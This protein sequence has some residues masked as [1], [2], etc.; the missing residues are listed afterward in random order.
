MKIF[1]AIANPETANEMHKLFLKHGV[2][3]FHETQTRS[4]NLPGNPE[5]R[6]DNWFSYS[7]IPV[8]SVV[9]FVLVTPGQASALL[10][11]I[12]KEN[13]QKGET[14][15]IRAFVLDVEQFV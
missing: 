12:K 7:K 2:N 15:S 8:N 1:V 3:A 10:V 14:D 5:H 9:Y 4:F 13:A 6:I 11:E